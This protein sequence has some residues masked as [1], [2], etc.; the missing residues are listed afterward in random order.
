MNDIESIARNISLE[1]FE[2]F[3][4]SQFI[5]DDTYMLKEFIGYFYESHKEIKRWNLNKWDVSRITDMSYMFYNLSTIEAL[6]ISDWNVSNVVNMDFMFYNCKSLKYVDI[7]K[8]NM[9]NV[10]SKAC[11]FERCHCDKLCRQYQYLFI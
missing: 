4:I 1:T 10:V 8:W 11:M 2:N 6:F 9:S 3:D 5:N 7:S